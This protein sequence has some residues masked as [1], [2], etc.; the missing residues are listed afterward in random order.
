MKA[1]IEHKREHEHCF[2]DI[3]HGNWM[4][5]WFLK[6]QSHGFLFKLLPIL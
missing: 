5:G 1:R 6:G 4:M 3:H 2:L